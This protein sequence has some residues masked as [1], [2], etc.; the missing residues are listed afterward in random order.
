M[1]NWSEELIHCRAC[2]RL[3]QWRNQVSFKKPK[4]FKHWIYWARPVLG[5]GDTNAELLIVGLAP[6]GHGGNR[7]G[8]LF[9]GDRSGEWLF[10][11]LYKFGFA[12]HPESKHFND[13]MELYNAYITAV[14]RCVPPKNKPST[15]ELKNCQT[16]LEAD[17]NNLPHLKA[18]LTLGGIATT[19]FGRLIG[20]K[21]AFKHGKIQ[22]A[23]YKSRTLTVFMSYHPSQQNTFTGRLTRQMWYKVFKDIKE[24]LSLKQI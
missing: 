22:Q 16:F 19:W 4:R 7:T 14:C 2:E 15:E 1:G 6:A 17:L 20:E 5:F 3:V 24:F 9:T 18:V 12:S 23:S 10:D 8:R 11:A 21:L 13:S